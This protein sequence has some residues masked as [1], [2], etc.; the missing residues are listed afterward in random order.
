MNR[1]AVDL[2]ERSYE[3][4]IGPGLIARAG[5]LIAPFAPSGRVF[6]VTD[7][8]VASLHWPAL[9]ASLDAEGLKSW[10]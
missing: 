9:M 2:G 6:V 3:V 4:R 10:T 5:E 7:K 1:V 8:N